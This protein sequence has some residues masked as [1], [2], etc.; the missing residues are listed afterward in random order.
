MYIYSEF[1][2]KPFGNLKYRKEYLMGM[3]KGMTEARRKSLIEELVIESFRQTTED[4]PIEIDNAK[5]ICMKCIA[6]I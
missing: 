2:N 1:F 6:V 5:D 4:A 3:V